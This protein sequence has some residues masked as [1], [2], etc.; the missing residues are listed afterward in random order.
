MCDLTHWYVW[1]D[2]FKI[3]VT[4]P[5]QMC[6]MTHS[7]VWHDPLMCWT[8]A[9]VTFK[10]VMSHMNESSHT[11]EWVTPHICL[12]ESYHEWMS[13]E[14]IAFH[15]RVMSHGW[16]SHVTY[17]SESCHIY[18][19]VMS[20]IWMSHVTHMNESCHTYEWALSHTYLYESCQINQSRT[21][22]IR[23]PSPAPDLVLKW[24][25]SH[26][27]WKEA[28]HTWMNHEP[29]AFQDPVL[30]DSFMCDMTQWH[31]WDDSC[32]TDCILWM[33]HEPIAF[34]DPAQRLIWCL[35][36]PCHIYGWAMSHI[37]LD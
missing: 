35:N 19:W 22:C 11:Y 7:R 29:I 21:N 3:C 28:C 27:S 16:M 8:R 23:W 14:L 34:H 15:E 18:E 13:H 1:H 25:M 5:I 24:V 6:D 36:E 32:D 17:M 20:H 26:I 31:V 30:Y 12:N 33:S 9:H 37:G 4:W 2:P 10:R